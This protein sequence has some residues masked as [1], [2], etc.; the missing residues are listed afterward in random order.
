L[1]APAPAEP[2]VNT[3]PP[4]TGLTAAQVAERVARG[5]TNNFHPRVGRSYFDIIRDNVFNVFTVTMLIMLTIVLL[6]GDYS[7]VFFAGFSVFT[8]ALFGTIQ[9]VYSK[10]KFDSLMAMSAPLVRVIRD[11]Q[12]TAVSLYDVVKDDVLPVE[13]GD[14]IVADGTVLQS[15]ALEIDESQLT[16]ESDA[17]LKEP[18]H[19][20]SSGSFCIAGSGLMRADVVGEHSTVN[21]LTSVAKAYRYVLT[22]TQR[23]INTLVQLSIFIMVVCTPML[24]VAGYMQLGVIVDLRNFQSAVIFVAS[25]VPQGLVLTATLS[26]TIGAIVISRRETLVQRVNAVE[27]MGNVTC[28]CFDKTGTLTQNRLSVA[29]MHRVNI[30]EGA[31]HDQLRLFVANLS[32]LNRTAGAIGAAVG[33]EKGDAPSRAKT[34]EVP[35]NSARKWSAV[36]FDDHTLILG[37]PERV[38]TSAEFELADEAREMAARGYRVVAFS[39]SDAAFADSALPEGRRALALIVLADTTRT[40]MKE[41]LD[42]FTAQG[43]ELKVISGDNLETVREVAT[44]AGMKIRKA[45]TGDQLAAMGEVEF[46]EA[47]REANLFARIEPDQKRQLVAALKKSGHYVAM[48]GDG[49]N[50][51]PSLKEAHLA[52]AM[53]DGAQITKDVAD[54]VLLN[55]ALTTLP[56]AFFEGRTITQIIFGTSKIFLVKNLY[57]LLFFLFVGFMFLPFPVTPIQISWL[58]FGVINLTAGLMSFRL[59]MPAPMQHFRRDVLDYVVTTGALGAVAATLVY[60]VVTFLRGGGDPG[61]MS[62][63]S[64]VVVFLTLLGLM[65]F[66]DVCGI[67]I[68]RPSTWL[69]NRRPFYLGLVAAPVTIIA[70]YLLPELGSFV[71]LS[72]AEWALVLA[73]FAIVVVLS[74]LGNRTRYFSNLVWRLTAGP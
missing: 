47:A 1:A 52:I 62:A 58:T 13:P 72:L 4:V 45:Y 8:N 57:S 24:F 56:E 23:R 61:M 66:W 63:R 25:V 54:I 35:F 2:L 27:S 18:G 33:W 71:P 49:V 42:A 48:T 37:A 9:E 70:G 36:I 43:V 55:N 26:L 5:E 20:V 19:K 11:G 16:G 68:L 31:L 38:L 59:Y 40:D 50:D 65:S 10:R 30:E 51:V 67:S 46:A 22:P 15:D 7:T 14:K 6:L 69:T 29:E 39:R 17:V 21:K 53:N 3:S 74:D 73:V 41:T 64:T 34:R 12:E 44:Q 60:A 32:A 28:L